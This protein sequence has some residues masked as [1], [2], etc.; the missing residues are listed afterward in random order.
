MD[1]QWV[2][3]DGNTVHATNIDQI[4]LTKDAVGNYK[5]FEDAYHY[6]VLVN[7]TGF[8]HAAR[9]Y[10]DGRKG[11]ITDSKRRIAWFGLVPPKLETERPLCRGL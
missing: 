4:S 7:S 2:F 9:I 8:H 11:H 10:L 5:Y 1:A 6:Y 3:V